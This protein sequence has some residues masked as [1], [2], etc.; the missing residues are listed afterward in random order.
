MRIVLILVSMQYWSI[1]AGQLSQAQSAVYNLTAHQLLE[2]LQTVS[3]SLVH[4]LSFSNM[5][6]LT[7]SHPLR[8]NHLTSIVLSSSTNPILPDSFP[9]SNSHQA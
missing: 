6:K 3:D 5:L 2:P 4:L 7:L 1:R 9:A 8:L